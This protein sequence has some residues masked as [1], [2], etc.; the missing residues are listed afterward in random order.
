MFKSKILQLGRVI[1]NRDV[2]VKNDPYMAQIRVG[3]LR[4]KCSIKENIPN[5][6][7][8]ARKCLFRKKFSIFGS[9]GRD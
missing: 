4:S 9:L 1:Q 8:F 5:L 2:Y 6:R 7:G 3:L